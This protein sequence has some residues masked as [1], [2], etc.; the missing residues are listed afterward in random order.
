MICLSVTSETRHDTRDQRESLRGRATWTKSGQNS[1]NFGKFWKILEK[2]CTHW[3]S[4]LLYQL[5]YLITLINIM[6][7]V[8]LGKSLKLTWFW[9]LGDFCSWRFAFYMLSQTELLSLCSIN[10][11]VAYINVLLLFG[12]NFPLFRGDVLP[13]R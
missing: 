9:F 13:L 3:C 8:F 2:I 11:N 12:R 6:R 7:F 5:Y 1:S 10:T 4:D